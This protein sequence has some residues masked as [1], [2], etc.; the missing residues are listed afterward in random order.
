MFVN[1]LLTAFPHSVSLVFLL[2]SS[3]V[4]PDPEPFSQV[5]VSEVGSETEYDQGI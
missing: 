1:S 5:T 4:D 2:V 3:V